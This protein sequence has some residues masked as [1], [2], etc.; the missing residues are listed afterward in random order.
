MRQRGEENGADNV[1]AW[2]KLYRR[3]LWEGLRYPVGKLHEDEFVT[4]RIF[5]RVNTA[6]L[7]PERL[8]HYVERTGSIMHMK[9][10][11]R[12]LDLIEALIG[13]VC[14][15]LDRNAVDLVPGFFSQL[16]DSIYRARQLD[17]SDG[18]VRKRL[19]EL[20][21]MFRTIPWNIVYDLP[22]KD[23]INYIGTRICPFL[24]WGRKTYGKKGAMKGD[25]Q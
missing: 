3:Q 22:L 6:V 8:Y 7:L 12:S 5:G 13:K 18:Q 23:R 11:L 10:T 25:A 2:N 1:V 15:L 24:F 14:F 20:F 16:K 21:Q 4:Y 19:E 9:Y 17:W